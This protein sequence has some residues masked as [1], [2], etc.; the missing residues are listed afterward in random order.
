MLIELGRLVNIS[1]ISLWQSILALPGISSQCYTRQRSIGCT[2]LWCTNQIALDFI[3]KALCRVELC[4]KFFCIVCNS[5]QSI[6]FSA[7]HNDC[8]T[9]SI[10]CLHCIVCFIALHCFSQPTYGEP[11]WQ[12][13]RAAA[14]SCYIAHPPLGSV[15]LC[16]SWIIRGDF[17]KHC[18]SHNGP[19]VLTPYLGQFLE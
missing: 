17:K 4:M 1:P 9:L 7:I 16:I 13:P 3:F 10:N 11:P 6:K 12:L 2:L 15:A 5:F 18:R 8:N 19:R 14:P